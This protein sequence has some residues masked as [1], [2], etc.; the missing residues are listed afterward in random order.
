MTQQERLTQKEQILVELHNN[1]GGLTA[2]DLR[3]RLPN[4]APRTLAT[5][6]WEMKSDGIISRVGGARGRYVYGITAKGKEML[7][8]SQKDP[9]TRLAD[10]LRGRTGA[11]AS[12]NDLLQVIEKAEDFRFLTG[13]IEWLV[14]RSPE[15]LNQRLDTEPLIQR[16]TDQALSYMGIDPENYRH[17]RESLEA[18]LR[19]T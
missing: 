15:L 7:P 16:L 5:T 19:L 8:G 17:Q 1:P 13:Y 6:L 2:M 18:L 11:D 9:L 3:D 10:S 14:E 12:F 4:I